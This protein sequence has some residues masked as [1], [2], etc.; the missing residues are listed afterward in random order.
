MRN[1]SSSLKSHLNSEVTTLATCWKL[2]RTDG[3]IFTFTDHDKDLIIETQK[4]ESIAG[5]L[6]LIFVII[7]TWLSIIWIWQDNFMRIK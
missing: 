7:V 1:L 3:K 2:T 5:L 6:L 4:Y